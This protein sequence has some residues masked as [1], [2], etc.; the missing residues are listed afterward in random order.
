MSGKFLIAYYSRK[1]ANY[2]SGNIVNLKVG[3]TEVAATIIQKITG[4]DMF[5]IETAKPYPKDYN[6]TTKIAQEDF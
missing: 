1:G 5:Y 2:V 3:N 4:S 6:E